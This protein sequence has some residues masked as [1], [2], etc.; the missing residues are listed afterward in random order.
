[1]ERGRANGESGSS[2][3]YGINLLLCLLP[4]ACVNGSLMSL[5][6]FDSA[7][8]FWADRTENIWSSYNQSRPDDGSVQR[9]KPALFIPQLSHKPGLHLIENATH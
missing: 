4:G 1:M 8:L 6:E 7:D 9:E 3:R 2:K 5:L